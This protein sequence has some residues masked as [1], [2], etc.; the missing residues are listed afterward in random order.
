VRSGGDG[1]PCRHGN[2]EV[3]TRELSLG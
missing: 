1:L 2:G 3:P